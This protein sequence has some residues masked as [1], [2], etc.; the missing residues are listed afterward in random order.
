MRVDRCGPRT[1]TGIKQ[2]LGLT[3]TG[4]DLIQPLA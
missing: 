3:A 1:V 2:Q 4:R